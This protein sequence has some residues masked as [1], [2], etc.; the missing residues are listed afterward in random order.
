MFFPTFWEDLRVLMY[1]I[2]SEM[3][4]HHLPFHTNKCMWSLCKNTSVVASPLQILGHTTR[5]S[6]IHCF[7]MISLGSCCGK[8]LGLWPCGT[9]QN[10]TRSQQPRAAQ[11][12]IS[13]G[14]NTALWN[15]F[16]WEW[17]WKTNLLSVLGNIARCAL[18]S[19]GI[20]WTASV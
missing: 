10:R 15:A 7:L 5:S 1:I 3:N 13:T 16:G 18:H 19:Q 6:F 11:V 14:V 2:A 12:K 17:C 9:N 4:F 8:D 20:V